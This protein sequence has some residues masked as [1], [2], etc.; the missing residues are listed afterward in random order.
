VSGKNASPTTFYNRFFNR[1]KH[2]F[3]KNT[4]LLFPAWIPHQVERL[5]KDEE[6]LIISFNANEA[7]GV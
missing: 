4:L 5:K 1:Y 7:P 3:K 6:R 2:E